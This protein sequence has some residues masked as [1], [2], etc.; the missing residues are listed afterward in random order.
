MVRAATLTLRFLLEL[1]LLA[2]LAF[3]GFTVGD[4]VTSI[5]L[6]IGAPLL[7][8]VIW[9]LFVAPKARYPVGLPVRVLIELVLFGAAAGALAAAGQP[10]LGLAFAVLAVLTSV[11]NAAQ[12]GQERR[13]T[14]IE[15]A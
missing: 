3:W 13:R 9:S 4:G 5:V 10:A 7:A 1:G 12:E 2:A 15:P 6:G 14:G 11:V 8:A